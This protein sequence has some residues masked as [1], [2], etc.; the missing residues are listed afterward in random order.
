MSGDKELALHLEEKGYDW[1][2]ED[3]ATA[4]KSEKSAV[5]V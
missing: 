4:D 5:S 1:V 2:R 3:S